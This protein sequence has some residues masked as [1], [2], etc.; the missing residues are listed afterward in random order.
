L[1]IVHHGYDEET[2]PMTTLQATFVPPAPALEMLPPSIAVNDH[3]EQ[4]RR[5][6]EWLAQGRVHDARMRRRMAWL[7][8]LLGGVLALWSLW[9]LA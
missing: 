9:A 3:V 6:A 7:A 5:W 1:S 8:G 2:P 4:D